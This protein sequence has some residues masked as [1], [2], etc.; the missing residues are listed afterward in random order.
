MTLLKILKKF[1]QKCHVSNLSKREPG[2]P[3]G[4]G[5][6]DSSPLGESPENIK[7]WLMNWENEPAQ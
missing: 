5:F 4:Q 2:N 7:S 3:K 6:K 1:H